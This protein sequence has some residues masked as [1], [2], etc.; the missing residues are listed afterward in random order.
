MLQHGRTPLDD[1]RPTILVSGPGTS[2]TFAAEPTGEP[3]M[4]RASVVFDKAGRWTYEIDDGF[5]QTHSYPA[6]DIGAAAATTEGETAGASEDGVPWLP[7]G[8]A[9]GVG[10]LVAATVRM[11]RA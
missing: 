7:L 4:Y 5:S 11:R 2:K 3:G 1:V 8:I 6:V 10:L 9:L